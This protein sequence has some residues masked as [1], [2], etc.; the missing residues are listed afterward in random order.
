MKSKRCCPILSKT[1]CEG[2]GAVK[3]KDSDEIRRLDTSHGVVFYAQYAISSSQA[4]TKDFFFSSRC[5]LMFSTIASALVRANTISDSMNQQSRCST[6]PDEVRLIFAI[7]SKLH[8]SRVIELVTQPIA[9]ISSMLA[10]PKKSTN[11][12]YTLTQRI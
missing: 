10:V 11:V 8:G 2:M 3:I 7:K 4:L 5:F 9:W 6:L 1:V 12:A